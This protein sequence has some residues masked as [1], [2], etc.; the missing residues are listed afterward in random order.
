[1]ANEIRTD[2]VKP[3][4]SPGDSVCDYPRT[5]R[6]AGANSKTIVIAGIVRKEPGGYDSSR[7]IRCFSSTYRPLSRPAA[8]A[9]HGCIHV[10]PRNYPPSAVARKEQGSEG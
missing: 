7:A 10:S 6:H 3:Q 2:N 4:I 9:D 5:G 1:M 8:R